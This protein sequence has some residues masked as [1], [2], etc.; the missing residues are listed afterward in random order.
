MRSDERSLMPAARLL[1]AFGSLTALV[2]ATPAE[3][4]RWVSEE[5]AWRLA[6]AL[7]LNALAALDRA[8]QG[9]LDSSEA[10]YQLL[11]PQFLGCHEER[12][13]AVSL[14]IRIRVLDERQW[15]DAFRRWYPALRP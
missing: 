6:A 2:R 7:R 14:Q 13:L 5:Q 11:A 9:C 1:A 12:L 3:L 15:G 4:A 10:I 8:Q